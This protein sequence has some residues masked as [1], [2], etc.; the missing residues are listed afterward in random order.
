VTNIGKYQDN[1]SEIFPEAAYSFD[2]RERKARTMLA[3]LKDFVKTDVRRMTLLDLGSST[4]IIAH[5]L[6]CHFGRVM[7]VDVDRS[8]VH[9]A[10]QTSKRSNL[11]FGLVDGMNLAFKHNMFDVVICA[12]IYEHVSDPVKL[13]EQIYRVLKPG[14]L[15]YFAADNR[16]WWWEPHYRLPFLAWLPRLMAHHYLRLAGKGDFYEERLLSRRSLRRLVGKFAVIDY[17]PK[18][19]RNPNLFYADYMLREGSVKFKFAN[20]VVKYAYWLCPGYIWLL[21]KRNGQIPKTKF[22]RST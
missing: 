4:G 21:Q 20:L 5:Y 6:A 16:L 1:F 9:F 3:V 13:L 7:G 10:W 11:S 2:L 15:C 14:G 19:I 12:H 22:W 8:A 17:T 18:I